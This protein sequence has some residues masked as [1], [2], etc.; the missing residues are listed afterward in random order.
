M[1]TCTGAFY[2]NSSSGQCEACA[3]GCASCTGNTNT[4]TDCETGYALFG[5]TCL[6]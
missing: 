2:G 3:T 5:S 6:T 1:A 4:C